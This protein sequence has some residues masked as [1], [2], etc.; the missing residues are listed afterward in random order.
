MFGLQQAEA[1]ERW[2][3]WRSEVMTAD[4][5]F[6][7]RQ[8]ETSWV[9]WV[10]LAVTVN[11]HING[12][13][14]KLTS[15]GSYFEPVVVLDV[16]KTSCYQMLPIIK[17]FNGSSRH[18]VMGRKYVLQINWNAEPCFKN[19]GNCE[20]LSVPFWVCHS[21]VISLQESEL[22]SLSSF[23]LGSVIHTLCWS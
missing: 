17:I 2:V 15:L 21:Y 22:H 20:D 16:L 4:W 19:H 18:Q 13:M 10:L 6:G 23:L 11:G 1:R 5:I 3:S 9:G 14:G 12:M 7:P 8:R